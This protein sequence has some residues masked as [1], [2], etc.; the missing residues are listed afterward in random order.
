[1]AATTPSEIATYFLIDDGLASRKRR[2]MLIDPVYR[3][4]GIG[5]AVHTQYQY[6]TVI[7][8]AE[9]L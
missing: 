5:Q 8:M 7:L 2:R 6:I 3:Y 1:L 9:I 4:V